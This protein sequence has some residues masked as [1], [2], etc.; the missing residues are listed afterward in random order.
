[1]TKYGIEIIEKTLKEIGGEMKN[2]VRIYLIGGGALSFKQIK[3]STKDIDIIFESKEEL[4]VFTEKLKEE[5]FREIHRK[6]QAYEKARGML[7]K[8]DKPTFDMFLGDVCGALQFTK[9]MKKRAEHWKDYGK[10]R[11]FILSNEDIFLFKS[12]AGRQG[13]LEDCA[14][15]IKQGLSWKVML[16]EIKRQKLLTEKEWI[17]HFASFISDLHNMYGVTIPILEETVKKGEEKLLRKLANKKI[18]Q[19]KNKEEICEELNITKEE[20]EEI[21]NTKS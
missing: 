11:V 1:M 13:D 15:L 14:E 2:T 5:G 7:G 12:I 19:G 18:E 6:F 9:G 21:R 4:R 3:E 10:V 16:K 8:E 17:I 20:Y